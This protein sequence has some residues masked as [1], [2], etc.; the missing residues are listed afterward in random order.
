MSR[1]RNRARWRRGARAPGIQAGAGQPATL[2][3]SPSVLSAEQEAWMRLVPGV[4]IAPELEAALADHD[5]EHCLALLQGSGA[6]AGRDAL[7]AWIHTWEADWDLARPYAAAAHEQRPGWATA[8]LLAKTLLEPDG[9]LGLAKA[10]QARVRELEREILADPDCPQPNREVWARCYLADTPAWT[11]ETVQVLETALS[12]APTSD[13]LHLYAARVR[14][15]AIDDNQG[16]C[17]HLEAIS[18]DRSHS[19]A[20]TLA[21]SEEWFL[22][23]APERAVAWAELLTTLA[24]YSAGLLLYQGEL[25]Y[26][27]G[28]A[29]RLAFVTGLLDAD[30]TEAGAAAAALLR[31]ALATKTQWGPEASVAATHVANQL[32]WRH[33]GFPECCLKDPVS[34]GWTRAIRPAG[35]GLIQELAEVLT[36]NH[37]RFSLPPRAWSFW[38]YQ[39]SVDAEPRDEEWFH[40]GWRAYQDERLA[41]DYAW[42]YFYSSQTADALRWLVIHASLCPPEKLAERLGPWRDMFAADGPHLLEAAASVFQEKIE[43]G[44]ESECQAVCCLVNKVLTTSGCGQ[45]PDLFVPIL[46]QLAKRFPDDHDVWFDL[47]YLLHRNTAARAEAIEA[48]RRAAALN[49]RS[50]ALWNL[51]LL[52]EGDDDEAAINAVEQLAEAWPEDEKL[53]EFLARL[54][55]AAGKRAAVR[56]ER[57]E[58][59]QSAP[60]R[61]SQL[62]PYQVQLLAVARSLPGAV[63]R[64]QLLR[65]SGMQAVWVDRH[66]KALA[67]RG[68]LVEDGAAWRLNPHIQHLVDRDLTHAVATRIIHTDTAI[69]FKSVFNS[70]REHDLYTQVLA[71]FPNM[72]VFPNMALQGVFQ[73]KRMQELLDPQVFRYYLMASVD[74]CVV[75]SATYFPVV[76]FELDSVFHDDAPQMK[77]DEKKDTIFR[78]GGVPLLRLRPHGAPT[79]ECLRQAVIDAV[80][81]LGSQLR[82]THDDLYAT[83][84]EIDFGQFA[85]SGTALLSV[86]TTTSDASVER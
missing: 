46:R 86:G 58:F 4:Q 29:E 55:T 64:E 82:A 14:R 48:N 49:P 74:L 53:A 24:G 33:D 32:P 45:R 3:S 76:A 61:W 9:L 16:A 30:T 28:D 5:W 72:L 69:A 42:Y 83:A 40:R 25:Y 60:G 56:Q 78:V 7:I 63:S 19:V 81:E 2:D 26:W 38:C 43:S 54:K 71:L 84:S 8:S 52:L 22:L 6:M 85:E 66:I 70:R 75:S 37:E 35:L 50:Y 18:I 67:A 65:V 36:E 62:N 12:L 79:R 80:R 15:V 77:R 31:V 34:G 73:Y 21:V 41:Y 27:V 23:A 10:N 57:E 20:L 51:A 11:Q 13:W 44:R 17:R 59:L 1:K 39:R 47:G 68:M